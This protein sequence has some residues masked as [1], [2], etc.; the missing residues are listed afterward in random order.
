MVVFFW[1]RCG[2]NDSVSRVDFL[3]ELDMVNQPRVAVLFSA[4]VDAECF[5]LVASEGLLG[6]SD[7]DIVKN[8]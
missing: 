2:L 5:W 8:I 7:C 3:S 4:P 6:T 1:V